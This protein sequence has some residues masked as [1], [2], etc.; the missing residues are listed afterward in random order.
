MNAIP[1]IPVPNQATPIDDPTIV[2]VFLFFLNQSK[3]F[4]PVF[5]ANK[6]FVLHFVSIVSVEI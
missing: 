3:I 5:L 1:T 6:V 2:N 4:P